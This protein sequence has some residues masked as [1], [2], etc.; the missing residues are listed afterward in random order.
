[1]IALVEVWPWQPHLKETIVDVAEQQQ[2]CL[3]KTQ[4]KYVRFAEIIPKLWL[5]LITLPPSSSTQT[6]Q[7]QY[8][9]H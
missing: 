7:T 9:Q 8:F 2:T 3:L 4:P 1:M 6:H 5:E